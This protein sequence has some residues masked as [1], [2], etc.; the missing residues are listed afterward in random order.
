MK[1]QMLLNLQ[2][3]LVENKFHAND[4]L[5]INFTKGASEISDSVIEQIINHYQSES[6]AQSA[7]EW[8]EW[9]QLN[10]DGKIVVNTVQK[11]NVLVPEF[12]ELDEVRRAEIIKCFFSPYIVDSIK[13]EEKY[14]KNLKNQR[15]QSD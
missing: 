7:K 1:I 12:Q 3:I 2:R 8:T 11:I 6:D 5:P 14:F 4:P 15:G 13:L 10:I 9:R